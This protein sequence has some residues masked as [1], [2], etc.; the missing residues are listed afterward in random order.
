[1]EK[2]QFIAGGVLVG[3]LFC[4]VPHSTCEEQPHREYRVAAETSNDIAALHE[5]HRTIVS[6]TAIPVK[7]ESTFNYE[8]S[9]HVG[10]L[11]A[12]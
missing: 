2:D 11:S 4:Q 3:L 5:E 6:T 7:S 8:A 1:M 10:S 9:T 12:R